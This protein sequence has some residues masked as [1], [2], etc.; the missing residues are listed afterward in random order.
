VLVSDS[1]QLIEAAINANNKHLGNHRRFCCQDL[2]F[3][4][5]IENSGRF[6]HSSPVW[7]QL[8]FLKEDL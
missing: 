2:I 5:G 4:D 7:P 8:D 3:Y 1:T 6:A